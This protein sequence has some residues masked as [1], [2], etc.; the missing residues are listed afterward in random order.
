MKL[1]L[2]LTLLITI[3]AFSSTCHAANIYRPDKSGDE[4]LQALIHDKA[5]KFQVKTFSDEITGLTLEYNL[6]L[7]ENYSPEKKYPVVFF[8]A[9]ASS[10]NKEPEFSLTQGYGALIWTEY[11]CIV[12]NPVY[13]VTVL[14]DHKGFVMSDYVE[15]TGRFVNWAVKNYA[16]DEARVYATGQSMGCMTFLVL[17]SKYQDLF[18]ACL[19]VSGQWN[20]NELKGLMTQKF[21]YVT[22]AGDDKAST[23]Q[24]EVIDMFDAEKVSCV[25]Y[26]NINA[27]NPGIIIP[28]KQQANFITFKVNSTIPDDYDMAQNYSEHMSSFDYAYKMQEFR[29]W[30]FAQTKGEEK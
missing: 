11:E 13:P 7:P 16:V 2:F 21:V 30:L 6:Y 20:I 10:V 1:K 15:L 4:V 17:A 19:F 26:K 27:K 3:L 18:T 14:D 8:I 29:E 28:D 9:D 12:I 5:N 25:W 24:K 23:G 22:S